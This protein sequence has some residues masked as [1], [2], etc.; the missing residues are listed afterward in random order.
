M[1][2]TSLSLADTVMDIIAQEG[3]V[4]REKVTLTATLEDLEI[5]SIDMVMILQGIEEQFDIYVPMDERMHTLKTVE[6]VVSNIQILLEQKEKGQ[7]E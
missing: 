2:S 6:D 4:A 7:G 5:Q 3:A 1:T